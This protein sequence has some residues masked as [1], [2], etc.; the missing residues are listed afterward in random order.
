MIGARLTRLFWVLSGAAILMATIVTVFAEEDGG[1]SKQ[2][3]PTDKRPLV[4]N[5]A[6]SSCVVD[7]A[8]IEDIRKAKEA[9]EAKAKELASKEAELKIKEQTLMDQL[10][11]LEKTREEIS[12]IQE[13]KKEEFQLRV[14]QLTDMI[15]TMSPK[16]AAKML[17]TLDEK[18][19]V[20]VMT[21]MDSPKLAKIMN[22]MDPVHSSRL[23]E[24]MTGVE[25]ARPSQ[26][27]KESGKQISEKG[28]DS[29]GESS[30]QTNGS[31]RQHASIEP[32]KLSSIQ[33]NSTQE[34][35][36]KTN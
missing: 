19:S 18:L 32:K 12:Q 13:S 33:P 5:S 35:G 27:E 15:L 6:P 29:H 28:G 36:A 25:Q 24:R 7:E 22:I 10:K 26:Q 8:A 3:P 2:S 30:I 1:K 34:K 11:K 21:R 14:Q 17:S 9:N 4:S 20:E 31:E 16:A 23:S